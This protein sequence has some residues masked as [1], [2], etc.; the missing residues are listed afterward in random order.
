MSP[1]KSRTFCGEYSLSLPTRSALQACHVDIKNIC[2]LCNS[3]VETDI[4]LLIF[5]AQQLE[6]FGSG[7]PWGTSPQWRFSKVPSISTIKSG[8]VA[9]MPWSC[10]PLGRVKCNVNVSIDLRN[11]RTSFGF[12]IRDHEGKFLAG[13]VGS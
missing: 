6:P 7:F 10:P 1:V 4:H 9:V 3:E 5:L 13:G 8:S 11:N 2:L 12:I